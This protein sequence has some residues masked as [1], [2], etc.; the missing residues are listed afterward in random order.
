MMASARWPDEAMFRYALPHILHL[1]A[2]LLFIGTV[3]F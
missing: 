2:A 1:F 3:F